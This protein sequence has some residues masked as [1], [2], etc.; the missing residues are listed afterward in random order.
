MHLE[1]YINIHACMLTHISIDMYICLV[2]CIHPYM[3]IHVH[4]V[5]TCRCTCLH[6]CNYICSGECSPVCVYA[7]AEY[8]TSRLDPRLPR[9]D[10]SR[11]FRWIWRTQVRQKGW[12]QNA[13]HSESLSACSSCES[14][15]LDPVPTD[16]C[17]AYQSPK[18][19]T[20]K[21]P[22]SMTHRAQ[23]SWAC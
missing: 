22:T 18:T 6:A 12:A 5:H 9:W 3:H 2:V 7:G 4:A 8:E 23:S 16:N 13:T 10:L 21:L 20:Q 11:S 14:S 15:A 19:S 17:K 1:L